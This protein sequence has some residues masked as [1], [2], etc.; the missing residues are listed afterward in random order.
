MR[1]VPCFQGDLRGGRCT[2]VQV[3]QT[4][5]KRVIFS[6]ASSASSGVLRHDVS[7][8]SAD[9]RPDVTTKSNIWIATRN[10][11]RH[12]TR[13]RTCCP[14]LAKLHSILTIYVI[15]Q[16]SD[17]HHRTTTTPQTQF[18]SKDNLLTIPVLKHSN[19]SHTSYHHRSP[20]QGFID[21]V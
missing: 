10:M 12:K 15:T 18:E 6:T 16:S 1:D 20:C 2:K 9:V 4:N 7:L 8:T 17:S 19:V 13:G 14:S 11:P 5:L 3:N 21:D